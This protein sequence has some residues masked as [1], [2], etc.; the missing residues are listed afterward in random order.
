MGGRALEVIPKPSNLNIFHPKIISSRLKFPQVGG[1]FL[2]PSDA[3]VRKQKSRWRRL[4]SSKVGA[5]SRIGDDFHVVDGQTT[6]PPSPHLH[7]PPRQRMNTGWI[8]HTRKFI[9]QPSG[10]RSGLSLTR[11]PCRK[12]T[13]AGKVDEQVVQGDNGL[14]TMVTR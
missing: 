14:A 13:T 11:N 4:E 10:L 3:K 5:K 2:L 9:L 12:M 1:G 8:V 7:R 6:R